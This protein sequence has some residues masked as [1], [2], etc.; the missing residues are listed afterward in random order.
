MTIAAR[1]KDVTADLLRSAG[2]PFSLLSASR[3]TLP[4]MIIE[5]VQRDA[6]V[7]RLMLRNKVRV[8]VGTSVSV[9]HTARL[10][11][12]RSIIFNSD[13]ADVVPLFAWLAYPLAHA[14]CTPEGVRMGRWSKKQVTYPGYHELAYLHPDLF[15]TDPCTCSD[16][17]LQPGT[18]YSLVRLSGFHA[19]HDVG[20]RGLSEDQVK[21]LVKILEKHGHVFISTETVLPDW[22]A[23]HRLPLPS[24]RMHDVLANAMCLVSDSQSVTREAAILGVPSFRCNTF[25]GRLSVIEELESRYGLTFGF[26]PDRHDEMLAQIETLLLRADIKSEWQLKRKRLL[27]EKVNVADWMTSFLQA[28]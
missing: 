6:G 10:C 25:V 17:G 11:G 18:A 2:L 1:E 22:A 20:E 19:H 12:A 28:S 13:D 3:R 21:R 26:T 8:A 5:L 7:L 15:S 9:S 24:H 16:L 23:D 14:V 27:D 4:G